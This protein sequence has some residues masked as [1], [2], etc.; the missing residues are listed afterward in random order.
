MLHSMSAQPSPNP[1]DAA[2][3]QF[4]DWLWLSAGLAQRTCDEYRGD[5]KRL[6][7][8]LQEQ[9]AT[10]DSA[11]PE[12]L[13]AV[14]GERRATIGPHAQRRYVAALRRYYQHRLEHQGIA[15]PLANFETPKLPARRPKA[16]TEEQVEALITAPDVETPQGVRDRA[17]LELMYAS[18][19]RVSELV[20]LPTHH[21]DRQSGTVKVMG[22]G[23]RER[24]VPVGE[25]ALDWIERYLVQRGKTSEKGLFLNRYGKPMSRQMFWK[26]VKTY[27]LRVNIPLALVSPHTL[28]HSFATHMMNS[29]GGADLRVL[30]L[31]LGHA[32][33][34]TT[35]IYT[36]VASGRLKELHAKHHPRG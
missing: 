6:A 8:W 21:L 14:F 4:C 28:R 18:G 5:L 36:H 31:L 17:M 35:A 1:A 10:L 3:D 12:T 29:E 22:K 16:L 34:N 9:G 26:L 11:D 23:E 2:I 25:I 30:Q 24:L 15:S 20:A 32:N 27:A 7:L 33:I 19:L 13:G